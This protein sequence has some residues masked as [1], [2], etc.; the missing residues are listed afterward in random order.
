MPVMPESARSSGPAPVA[1][2]AHIF[3]LKEFYAHAGLA[4]PRVEVIPG[5]RV[6][7]P[8]Q[9]LL[10]HSNDM[11]PTLEEFFKSDIHLE[12]LSRERRGDFYFRE[13]ILRLNGSDQP[14]EFG[15][16]KVYVGR[17][18]EEAQDLI[19]EEHVPLGRILKDCGVHHRTEAKAFLR[20]QSDA[21]INQAFGLDRP[22]E[23]FGRKAVISDLQ[24][25][26]LSEIVEILPPLKAV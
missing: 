5:D 18:P 19:L 26:P 25:R 15:A 10:V 4:L 23:L 14:V 17:F 9:T 12:I 3:P 2:D 24:G 6:P 20:V 13:V 16:N 7:G 8:Y 11:T 22:T 21:L 1:G